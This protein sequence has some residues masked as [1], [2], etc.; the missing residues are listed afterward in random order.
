MESTVIKQNYAR[1]IL[2]DLAAFLVIF[3]APAAVHLTGI[4]L[5]MIEPM[6]VMLV[7]SMA[8]GSRNNSILLALT[9]PLFSFFVS[10]HP[11]FIKMIIISGELL[12]NV[13]LFYLLTARSVRPGVAMLLAIFISKTACYLTYWPVF[14]LD[15][16][17][18]E[19]Q[20]VFLTVQVIT[21]LIFSS[22]IMVVLNKKQQ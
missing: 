14:S 2:I 12:L 20:P 19:A 6:R 9:L 22:Y 15:F 8:H 1:N 10:G 4:P 16:L 5:Y 7:L 18:D 13:V 3:L 11:E 21:T 17:I